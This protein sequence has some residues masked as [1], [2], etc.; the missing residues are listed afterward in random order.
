LSATTA[1]ADSIFRESI[2]DYAVNGCVFVG[3]GDTPRASTHV[4]YLALPV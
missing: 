4:G 1:G 2:S 3:V